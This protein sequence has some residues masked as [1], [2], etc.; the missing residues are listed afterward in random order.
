MF[1]LF[2]I[3]ISLLCVSVRANSGATFVPELELIP[4]P[5]H[6]K[7]IPITNAYDFLSSYMSAGRISGFGISVNQIA[8]TVTIADGYEILRS[9]D[10]KSAQAWPYFIAGDTFTIP[11]NSIRYIITDYNGG[12]PQ[13][14]IVDDITTVPCQSRCVLYIVTRCNTM[15]S[16]ISIGDYTRDFFADFA[17]RKAVVSYLEHGAGVDLT[18]TGTLNLAVTSGIFYVVNNLLTTP[19]FDTSG[20]DTFRYIYR[21]GAGGFTYVDSQTA[22]DA[23]HYD[24]GSGTLAVTNNNRYVNHFVYM[25]VNNPSRLIVVYG[26]EEYKSVGEALAETPPTASDLPNEMGEYGTS[27]LIARV[28]VRQ[29]GSAFASI[30]QPWETA[31]EHEII[32][33]HNELDELQGGTTNEYYH[34]TSDEYT[35]YHPYLNASNDFTS[36]LFL[37][38]ISASTGGADLRIDTGTDEV[39]YDSSSMRYKS[40]IRYDL[41]GGYLINKLEPAFY[42]S[43]ATGLPQYGLIAED[44]HDVTPLVTYSRNGQVEGYNKGDLVPFLV[45][46]QRHVIELL[47]DLCAQTEN[48]KLKSCK[49]FTKGYK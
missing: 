5:D 9:A 17:R 35:L 23:L 42:T 34:H 40:N 7:G 46:S 11:A 29:A 47:L 32:T 15:I 18:H 2:L 28:V 10:T 36:T 31:F 39:F 1:K 16:Y 3:F 25:V 14:D 37:S 30:S 19:A 44:V 22:I 33:N 49:D 45:A 43:N 41:S 6:N 38:G 26:H 24:D 48:S 13:L 21:N 20:A 27:R 12:S 4:Y 8:G